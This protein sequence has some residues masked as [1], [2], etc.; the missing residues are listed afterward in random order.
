MSSFVP[1]VTPTPKTAQLHQF[2]SRELVPRSGGAAPT[3]PVLQAEAINLATK[4]R[5]I[6]AG[7]PLANP[8]DPSV[9][10]AVS[11]I[12]AAVLAAPTRLS[13]PELKLQEKPAATDAPASGGTPQIDLEKDGD[14]VSRIKVNCVCGET[15]V[16]DCM[17]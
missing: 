13:L 11:A 6:L 1:L 8:D 4:L 10:A 9:E 15:I 16:L 12:Q 7:L 17:Y 5:V 3:P 14:K 2:V